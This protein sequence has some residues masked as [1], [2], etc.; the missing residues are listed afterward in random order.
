M[1]SKSRFYSVEKCGID[2]SVIRA[3][4][5]L[6]RKRPRVRFPS[7]APFKNIHLSHF[8]EQEPTRSFTKVPRAT[9]FVICGKS[10]ESESSG[11]LKDSGAEGLCALS[12]C[13]K[14]SSIF[15]LCGYGHPSRASGSTPPGSSSRPHNSFQTALCGGAHFLGFPWPVF[16]HRHAHLIFPTNKEALMK[17]KYTRAQVKKVKALKAKGHTL[18]AISAMTMVPEGSITHLCKSDLRTRPEKIKR[19]AAR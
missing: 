8:S 15:N 14:V 16:G 19:Q 17:T 2:V 1:N 6:V 3:H 13:T 9:L 18:L 5:S 7:W 4:A 11:F 10:V 12:D